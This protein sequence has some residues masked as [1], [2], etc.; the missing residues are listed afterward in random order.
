[1]KTSFIEECLRRIMVV[2]LKKGG[3]GNHS[4]AVNWALRLLKTQNTVSKEMEQ[5]ISA[6]IKRGN[7]SLPKILN[8]LSEGDKLLWG[9]RAIANFIQESWLKS[10]IETARVL[11]RKLSDD[12]LAS[13]VGALAKEDNPKMKDIVKAC[14]L[15]NSDE[16]R[17]CVVK[18]AISVLD[19]YHAVEI[20]DILPAKQR[21]SAS[22]L[23]KDFIKKYPWLVFEA[24]SL[25]ELLPEEEA[26]MNWKIIRKNCV[27]E[28]NLDA[29]EKVAQKM[30]EKLS[31]EELRKIIIACKKDSYYETAIRASKL[32]NVEFSE[33]EKKEVV[34]QMLNKKDLH[35]ARK[36][37]NDLFSGK[38]TEVIKVYFLEQIITALIIEGHDDSFENAAKISKELSIEKTIIYLERI[39]LGWLKILETGGFV[40]MPKIEEVITELELLKEKAE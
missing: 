37:V 7:Y 4:E 20:V 13:I 18:Y 24:I 36:A 12:E 17:I 19:I 5:V 21:G 15:I 29:A 28:G 38:E 22:R 9:E 33:T 30:R 23:F 16:K 40:Y 14:R 32:L 27:S 3:D 25:N 39:L 26:K 8:A 10:A 34:Q 2:F 31:S 1:M 11:G 6:C 35:S